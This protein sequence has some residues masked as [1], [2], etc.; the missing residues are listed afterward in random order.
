MATLCCLDK[1]GNYSA[2]LFQCLKLL[3][4]R[5]AWRS[6]PIQT[7][8]FIEKLFPDLSFQQ[9]VL[10]WRKYRHEPWSIEKLFSDSSFIGLAKALLKN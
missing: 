7:Q 1:C 6:A 8:P 5:S 4:K 10:A 3:L 9:I 2:R